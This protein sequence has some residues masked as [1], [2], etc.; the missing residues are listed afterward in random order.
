MEEDSRVKKGTFLIY[1]FSAT[2]FGILLAYRA[3]I[4]SLIL[5]NS[6]VRKVM[7]RR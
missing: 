3:V 5:T 7:E 4:F 2:P 6:T 1:S